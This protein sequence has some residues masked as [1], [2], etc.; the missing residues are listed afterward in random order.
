MI[1]EQTR[2]MQQQIIR[3]RTKWGRVNET[4]QYSICSCAPHFDEKDVAV[5]NKNCDA[6]V[7]PKS[8]SRE[9]QR[10]NRGFRSERGNKQSTIQTPVVVIEPTEQLLQELLKLLNTLLDKKNCND[11]ENDI[12]Q[13]R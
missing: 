5:E 9:M 4:N 8:A 3:Q 7:R 10:N 13:K 11:I 2:R 6:G 12:E 1:C